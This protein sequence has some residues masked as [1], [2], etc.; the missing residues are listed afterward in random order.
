[1]QHLQTNRAF[2]HFSLAQTGKSAVVEK[3]QTYIIFQPKSRLLAQLQ[4]RLYSTCRSKCFYNIYSYQDKSI[5]SDRHADQGY[6]SWGQMGLL[7]SNTF[8]P[9]LYLELPQELLSYVVQITSQQQ[10]F[11]DS[12]ITTQ[13]I[14]IQQKPSFGFCSP[15]E[16]Q[17]FTEKRL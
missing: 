9:G 1:M 17:F 8:G 6:C 13:P 7:Q 14:V 5:S 16:S 12:I 10:F 4:P 2:L 15:S 11:V 3:L